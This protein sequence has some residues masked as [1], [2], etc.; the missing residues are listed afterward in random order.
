MS[1]RRV[2]LQ[3]FKRGQSVFDHLN[4]AFPAHV[5]ARACR[6]KRKGNVN[7]NP[8]NLAKT[9]SIVKTV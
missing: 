4:Y 2:A 1:T 7:Q 5:V 6:V 8:L 9:A 3:L